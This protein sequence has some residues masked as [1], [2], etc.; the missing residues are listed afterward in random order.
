V[1]LGSAA[2]VAALLAPGHAAKDDA[3]GQEDCGDG[4]VCEAEAQIALVHGEGRVQ[5]PDR[6]TEVPDPIEISAH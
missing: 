4:G 1:G 6:G 5:E 2:V 3:G